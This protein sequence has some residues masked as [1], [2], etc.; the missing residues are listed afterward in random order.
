MGKPYNFIPLLKTMTHKNTNGKL[1]GKIE[2]EIKVLNA[3]HVS[4]TNYDMDNKQNLFKKFFMIGNKYAIPGTSI[5]G[6]I[7]NIAESTSYS[8]LDSGKDKAKYIPSYN[9]RCT[10]DEFCIICDMFGAM[11]KR[12][13]IRVGDF[14]YEEGT[15]KNTVLALPVLRTPNFKLSYTEDGILK[16][17]KIYNHGIESILK[18]GNYNCECFL[19]DSTF[20]GTIIYEDLDEEELNL[21]CYALSL[22][23][24]FNHKI[25][26]G[27]PA[28]YGSI[29][30]TTNQKEYTDRAKR[31][32]KECS[33]D[34]KKNIEFLAENYSYKNA[35]KKPDYDGLE[36]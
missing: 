29:E 16:G 26:Y 36:Y 12:S 11:G 13:K 30:I 32:E 18:K 14:M 15:G 10:R 19:R 8:C 34:I 24:S 7:R 22:S 9:K 31:Y 23:G 28:Y 35:K 1:R 27:K 6:M 25:G 4:Q 3:I 17:H 21:L 20:K 2:L 33:S 5:K